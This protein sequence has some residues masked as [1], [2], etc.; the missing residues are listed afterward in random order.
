[1]NSTLT[2]RPKQA[3][4]NNISLRNLCKLTLIKTVCV[5]YSVLLC[6]QYTGRGTVIKKSPIFWTECL[7]MPKILEQ[8]VLD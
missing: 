6:R 4:Q 7:K 1:M 5:L 2:N 8:A 3:F